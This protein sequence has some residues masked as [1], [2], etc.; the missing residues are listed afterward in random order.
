ME[1]E[2]RLFKFSSIGG[3]KKVSKRKQTSIFGRAGPIVFELCMQR[4]GDLIKHIPS[5]QQAQQR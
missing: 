1:E 4:A 3:R 2:E 5:Q